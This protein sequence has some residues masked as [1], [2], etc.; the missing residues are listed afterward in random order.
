M[1]VATEI[2]AVTLTFMPAGVAVCV[3]F[4]K[5]TCGLY[6]KSVYNLKF[7]IVNHAPVCSVAYDCNRK[8]RS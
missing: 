7:T 3:R 1:S 4:P 8:L 6:Y 5:Q 2:A